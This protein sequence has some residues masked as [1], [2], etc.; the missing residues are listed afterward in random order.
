MRARP[1]DL[2]AQFFAYAQMRKLRVVRQGD[3]VRSILG[4]SVEQERKLL[5]RLARTKRI[6]RVRRGLYLVP[7][8]LSIGGTWT[9]SETLAINTLI[10]DRKG[11]YQISGPNAFNRYGYS[12]QVPNRLYAYNNRIS[13]L[14]KVGVVN[15]TLIKVADQRLG[16]VVNEKA[17][18]GE[19]AAYASRG[20]TLIDAVYDWR[21]FGTLPRAYEWIRQ[22][23]ATKKVAAAELVRLAL[24][25]GDVGTIRRIGAVLE[26]EGVDAKQ[27]KPLSA[28]LRSAINPLPMV[29]GR[30]R[31]GTVDA[32]WGVV[33]NDGD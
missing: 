15:I 3:L 12:E 11:R 4:L 33:W 30:P 8:R 22:D 6:A 27:L 13:G 14:R 16:D 26:R 21:R 7:S 10:A 23:L 20:R 24:R 9:P 29:P 1:R 19:V 31:G 17:D 18:D 32:K 2:A 5:S 25:Y 28:K